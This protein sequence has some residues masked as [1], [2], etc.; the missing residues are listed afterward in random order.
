MD[1]FIKENSQFR[2]LDAAMRKVVVTKT[3]M[4]FTVPHA[5]SAA[6]H[7]ID[8]TAH[9]D[10]ASETLPA[11]E[12]TCNAKGPQHDGNIIRDSPIDP[13][14]TCEMTTVQAE[15]S[16]PGKP[17][18]D[19][20]SMPGIANVAPRY[21]SGVG[22]F[23]QANLGFDPQDQFN[24]FAPSELKES[25][26]TT[27]GYMFFFN[28]EGLHGRAPRKYAPIVHISSWLTVDH[29]SLIENE[30]GA[31][32]MFDVTLQLGEKEF[33]QF[34]ETVCL[35]VNGPINGIEEYQKVIEQTVHCLFNLYFIRHMLSLLSTQESGK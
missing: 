2:G 17:I 20:N 5:E 13:K 33:D 16:A 22:D 23:G 19:F 30:E 3:P 14:A 27:N 24:A 28:E 15:F 12:P 34:S 21:A 26:F 35:D 1:D 31:N 9:A 11:T 32:L 4:V 25:F 10:A 8:V 6:F 18:Y 7:D 29:K